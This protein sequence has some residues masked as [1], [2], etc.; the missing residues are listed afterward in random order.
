MRERAVGVRRSSQVLLFILALLAVC[1]ACAEEW[2][3]V[4]KPGD[5][6][7]NLTTRY[8]DGIRYWPRIQQLNHITSPTTIPPATRLRI[9]VEWLRVRPAFA[10][11]TYLE[12]R[13]SAMTAGAEKPLL[14]GMQL[15]SGDEVRTTPNSNATLEF[16]D[17]S[18]LLLLAE[19][20]LR[21]VRLRTFENTDLFQTQVHL[22]RGH[23]ENLVRPIGD[24]PGRFEIST[25]A[26]TTA[27]RGTDYRV[28]ADAG[29]ARTEVLG[30]KVSVRTAA[31]AVEVPSGFG[32][33]AAKDTAPK[34][35]TA[36][37]PPPD[38]LSIPA[39]LERV[40]LAFKLAPVAHAHGYRLQVA[41]DA[42]FATLVFDGMSSSEILQ[43]ADLPDGEY[44]A[45]VRAIDAAGLEGRNAERW[46]T[47]NARPEPPVIV[48]PA[49]GAGVTD[50]QPVFAWAERPEITRYHLQLARASNFVE[51][52]IDAE[53]TTA[54]LKSSVTLPP[55]KYFWRVAALDAREG[56]GPFSDVQEFR[57]VLPGPTVDAP[58]VRDKEMTLRW[59]AALPGQ[60]SQ[61]QLANNERFNP[62]LLD[63]RTAE[64]QVVIPRPPGGTYFIRTRTI[65]VD[66][67]EGPFG[68][69]Q[70]IE[71]PAA[72]GKWWLLVLPLLPFLL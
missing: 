30:G 65:D 48:N 46:F 10:T 34:T 69:P 31:A 64:A 14:V 23:A 7:W 9:P 59:R 55:G 57:R 42:G 13:G 71:V 11:V 12:G 33:V 63:T 35:P 5:N 70:H 38:A 15:A 1:G 16:G 56:A 20:A 26:A 25:P 47:L 68:A 45:R 72:N 8:L 17:G 22:C 50:E 21:L 24:G 40:P 43:G 58:A 39:L 4:V 41:R 28:H 54:K 49:P 18:R 51:R 66:G 44:V 19:S 2:L 29:E 67:F 52:L 36:L 37:L 53:L 62:L 3:Y 61:V 6:P 27:V 32:S 60:Q